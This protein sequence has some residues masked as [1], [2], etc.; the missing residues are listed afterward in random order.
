[1]MPEKVLEGLSSNLGVCNIASGYQGSHGF[2]F[3]TYWPGEV[4]QATQ[5]VK[6]LTSLLNKW[7]LAGLE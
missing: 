4:G 5:P 1:M 7:R 3:A 6:S 2:S